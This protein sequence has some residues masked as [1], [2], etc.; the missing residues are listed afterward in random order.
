MAAELEAWAIPERVTQE[1]DSL[2]DRQA[3][4]G[5]VE[6]IITC[7]RTKVPGLAV[8]DGALRNLVTLRASR[9]AR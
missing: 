6:S 1:I 7:L 3:G 5:S 8:D 9:R 2:L 4:V